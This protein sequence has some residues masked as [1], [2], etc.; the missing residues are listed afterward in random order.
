MPRQDL[1]FPTAT[2]ERQLNE[3]DALA[4]AQQWSQA[5]D[6]Y[7]AVFMHLDGVADRERRG[8]ALLGGGVGAAIGL[9]IGL[10]PLGMAVGAYVGYRLAKGFDDNGAAIYHK[11]P[12]LAVYRRAQEGVLHA[13]RELRRRP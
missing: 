11:T 12:Y 13:D 7:S 2:L 4:T 10:G 1:L 9:V 5:F 8:G 3:A 6:L